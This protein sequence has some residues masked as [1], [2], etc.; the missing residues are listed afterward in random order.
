MKYFIETFGCQMNGHDSEKLAGMLTA[1]GHLKSGSVDDADLIIVN[2]CCV[3]ENAENRIYGHLGYL[4]RLKEDKKELIIAVCGCMAQRAESVKKFI[5]IYNADIVFGTFNIPDFPRLLDEYINTG[6]R[7]VEIKDS[8][9]EIIAEP[10]PVRE[11]KFKASINVI[12][13]CDNFCS[14]CI[15][16]YVRGRERSRPFADVVEQARR[17]SAGGAIELMLLGQNVNS[18]GRDLKTKSSF[19][20]L[21]YAVS[22]VD[23]IK[24]I[25]FMTSNPKDLSDE[26]IHVMAERA[27]VC[28]H[29]HLPLQ[30]GSDSILKAMN[31][32]YTKEQYI[33]LAEKVRRTVPGV[34]VTT[35]IIVGFPGETDDDFA[36][37]LDVVKSV[38]FNNA[39]TFIYS[40]RKG[41]PAA[42]MDNQTDES[43]VKERF[44]QLLA[45]LSDGISRINNA[46]LGTTVPVLAEESNREAFTLNGRTDDN[47]LVHFK[48]DQALIGRIIDVKITECK[49][50]YLTG[51]A[52]GGSA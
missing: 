39:F 36:D 20:E 45:L 8:H 25:R 44:D 34:S 11:K 7:I 2:T 19:A 15:V 51:T 40:K 23:G 30:S 17:L 18:Y 43:I 48:G 42:D 33:G 29:L 12:Y 41:T 47:T 9:P 28:K 16:P 14:Y 37:T 21:L 22:R 38:S 52:G 27:N 49:T 31:R 4:K 24:R 50:Y 32:H 5:G 1:A 6:K 46:R 35:D 10:E 26:L 3:R 13:G